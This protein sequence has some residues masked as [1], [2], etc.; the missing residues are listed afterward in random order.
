MTGDD[1]VN[2]GA[3]LTAGLPRLPPRPRPAPGAPNI[4]AIVLDDVGFAQLGCFGSGIATPNVDRLAAGGL[5]YNRFHVTA[6]CSPTRAAFLT[7]RNHHAVGMGF[8]ADIPLSYPGYSGRVPPSA[9][10]L[11]R[12]LR[13]AGY[14][15]LAVGKWHLTP[16]FERSAAGP[17]TAW[18]LGFGFERYYGFLNGD[19][20]HWAPLLVADNHYIDQ[21]GGADG[22][23]HLS[24]DL[25]AT[26]VRYLLDQQ[27]AAPGKPFFLYFALGAAHAPH[28]VAPRWAEPY[29]GQF[30]RGWDAWR[31]DIFARQ[32]D[33]GLIP[34]GTILTPRPGWVADWNELSGDERRMYSRQQEVFAGFLSHAD[35]QIGRLT[36]LLEDLGQLDNTLILLLSD[37]G[38]SAEG[39]AEGSFNEHRFS[40]RIRDTLEGNLAHYDDWGG[41]RTYNHYSWGWAWAGNT[42][43]RLWKR[44]TWL[45]GTRT[46]LIIHWPGG[47]RA[48]GA[49]RSRFTHVT[50]LFP[51]ILDVAGVPV[52]AEVDGVAQQR[53]NGVSIRPSFE[54]PEAACGHD[55]Q[56]FE[57]LG[58]RSIV[59]GPWKATT[60]HVSAGI[61]D[62]EARLAGSRRFEDDRWALFDLDSDFSEAT[63]VAAD[64]PEVVSDLRWLWLTEAERNHV[65]P[66]GDA[67]T[68]AFDAFI[69]PA[70]P[71]GTDRT[72]RPGG[73]PVHDESL[74]LLLRGFRITAEVVAAEESDGVLLALGDWN[75]GYALFAAG[76]HLAFTVSRAGELIEVTADRPIPPGPGRLGVG[77]LPGPQGSGTIQLLHNE[78]TVAELAFDGGFPLTFQHGGAGLL[79][80]SDA[81]LP[82]SPRYTVPAPWNGTLASV[83]FQ[84]PPG[85]QPDLPAT[86]RTALH[87]D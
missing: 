82:V 49:V 61:P 59:H 48:A 60:D 18:P 46:P 62:E 67:P 78:T 38:A 33:S 26:A 24:E 57:M 63:D 9:A 6:L 37:N 17:F 2:D 66:I 87:S 25:A 85:P 75:G 55:T 76:G 23:Y 3:R 5:R 39:G 45:G 69:G 35:A 14:S 58:S 32:W 77:Y 42:P 72:Y 19:A 86:L 22:D 53:L 83:R 13:D 21:P 81:G 27:Q 44:Y 28:H 15:T 29:R 70:W 56:Y 1:A 54:D 47:F 71:A 11:P 30:D 40:S 43:F 20:N 50:D 16:R 79:L 41:P 80:G 31:R 84:T 51:T 8:L 7:G 10:P 65:L 73:G 4:V 34:A 64:H 74:P 68:A 12:L 36:R 52:P